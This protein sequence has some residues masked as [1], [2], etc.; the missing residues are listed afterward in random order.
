MKFTELPLSEQVLKGVTSAGFTECTE[1]QQRVLP[2]SL[3][4]KD[5][6]IQSKTGSG[7]TAVYVLTILEKF[8]QAAKEGKTHPKALIVAPTRELAVQ[9]EEDTL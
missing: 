8:V 1:V 3:D 7:K 6:M 5:V 2:V 4:Q 9:I